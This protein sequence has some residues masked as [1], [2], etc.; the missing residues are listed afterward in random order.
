MAECLEWFLADFPPNLHPWYLRQICGGSKAHNPNLGRHD[1]NWTKVLIN[2]LD[3]LYLKGKPYLRYHILKKNPKCIST[4]YLPQEKDQASVDVLLYILSVETLILGYK[5]DFGQEIIKGS[6][7]E[8][9]C[10][11][12]IWKTSMGSHVSPGW[13][14]SLERLLAPC[15]KEWS[16][17][18]TNS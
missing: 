14:P 18:W 5:N 2:R 4:M 17:T 6:I 15:K 13:C 12:L 1:A 7:H 16:K 8:K 3:Y 9:Y 11:L 10:L